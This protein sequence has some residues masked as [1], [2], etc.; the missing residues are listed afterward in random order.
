MRVEELSWSFV[1]VAMMIYIALGGFRVDGH[2]RIQPRSE[3]HLSLHTAT[4][5]G[6]LNFKDGLIF[7]SAS[8]R[9]HALDSLHKGTLDITRTASSFQWTFMGFGCHKQDRN[10]LCSRSA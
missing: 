5:D 7:E 8:R 10:W 6:Q 4:F 3:S 9:K 1:V 2:Q